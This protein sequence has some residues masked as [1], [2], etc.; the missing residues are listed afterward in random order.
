MRCGCNDKAYVRIYVRTVYE[1]YF[2]KKFGK[3]VHARK[4][5]MENFL[6]FKLILESVDRLLKIELVAK[7]GSFFDSFD[8]KE[9]NQNSLVY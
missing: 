3:S 5:R 7:K 8:K 2:G 6:C 9:H 1:K 4:Y